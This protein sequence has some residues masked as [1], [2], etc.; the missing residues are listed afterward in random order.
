M[1]GLK[2]VSKIAHALSDPGRAKALLALRG[3][4]LCV[5]QV[6]ELLKLSFPTVS[7]HISILEDAGLLLAEK[8]GKWS[9]CRLPGK[10]GDKTALA[11]IRW[12]SSAADS[13]GVAEIEIPKPLRTSGKGGP[14]C[15]DGGRRRQ[16]NG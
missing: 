7:R 15:G 6:V 8:R 11:A 14:C 4:E 10:G 12:L 3:R 5:C 2:R 16:A 9:Y 1:D 13:L